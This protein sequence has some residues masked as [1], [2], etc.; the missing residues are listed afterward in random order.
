MKAGP[1][2]TSR[3][4]EELRQAGAGATGRLRFVKRY[5]PEIILPSE[6]IL[7]AVYGSGDPAP[8]WLSLQTSILIATNLR[9]I[10]I[11]HELGR[12]TTDEFSYEVVSGIKQEHA[13]R[14]IDITLHAAVGNFII[15]D[16]QA[17]SAEKF[18]R[19]IEE[20]RLE[21]PPST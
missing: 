19:L 15:N 3:I 2:H 16:A 1:N 8:K 6:H 20:K 13:G 14:F 10:F 9:I 21:Q 11:D 17:A 18:V 7:A 5:L 12:T 4:I